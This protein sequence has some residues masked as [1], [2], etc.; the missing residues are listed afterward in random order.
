M[1][2]V[3]KNILNRSFLFDKGVIDCIRDIFFDTCTVESM[4]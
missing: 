3:E 2:I 1:L 4:I